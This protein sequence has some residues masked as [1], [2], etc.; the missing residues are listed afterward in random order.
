VE[1]IDLGGKKAMSVDVTLTNSQAQINVSALNA[2]I[3]VVVITTNTKVY[4]TKL[5]VK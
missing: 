3:Y 5:S 2:G 1:L 4:T